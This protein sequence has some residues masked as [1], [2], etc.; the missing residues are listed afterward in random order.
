[1]RNPRASGVLHKLVAMMGHQNA[2][3]IPQKTLAKVCGCS[4]RTIRNALPDLISGNW[5][6]VVQLGP[7]GS[8]NAYIVNSSVAWGEKR[9]HLHLS[10]FDARIVADADDQ[11][12]HRLDQRT[13]LR[14][15]PVL[16]PGETQLPAGDG[17]PPPSQP[18]LPGMEPDLPALHEEEER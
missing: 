14:R 15:I 7:A 9:D 2:V 5:I 16:F 8:V 10:V 6:Q 12:D 3:V 11:P 18:S 1:M 4:E 17:L 13:E